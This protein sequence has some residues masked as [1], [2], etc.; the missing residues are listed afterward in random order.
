MKTCK[1]CNKELSLNEF[2]KHSAMVSG[3]LNF[4]K[5]CVKE[6]VH[7]HRRD[8]IDKYRILDK[9]I[10]QKP[11]VIKYRR[12]MTKAWIK[13]NPEAYKAQYLL[14]NAVRDKRIKKLTSCEKCGKPHYRLNGHHEDYSKPLEVIWLCPVCHSAEHY[15]E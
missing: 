10:R 7:K 2:Y 12:E 6:R 3:Y 5:T 1:K 14:R 13:R 15:K 4:C 11:K 9:A 8:N